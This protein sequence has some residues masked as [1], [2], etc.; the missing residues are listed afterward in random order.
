MAKPIFKTGAVFIN[1]ERYG[2]TGITIKDTAQE[3][4]GTDGA[5]GGELEKVAAFPQVG[6]SFSAFIT[7]YNNIPRVGVGYDVYILADAFAYYGRVRFLSVTASGAINEAHVYEIEGKYISNPLRAGAELLK[8]PN[9]QKGFSSVGVA[10]DWSQWGC[11]EGVVCSGEREG[12]SGL[13]YQKVTVPPYDGAS[14]ASHNTNYESYHKTGD[15][16]KFISLVDF[17]VRGAIPT[18]FYI[19]LVGADSSDQI[20]SEI[21]LGKRYL[22]K[23]FFTISIFDGKRFKIGF[24]NSIPEGATGDAEINIFYASLREIK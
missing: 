6:F 17:S 10:D 1:G 11:D 24:P 9:F 23:S 15:E 16:Y 5:S 2:V 4:D 14:S 8:N 21:S 20:I 13:W 7:D 22:W 3:L 12:K 19:S 18:S